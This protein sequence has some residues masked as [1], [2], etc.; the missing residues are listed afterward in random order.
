M[1]TDWEKYVIYG[2]I[3]ERR[4][5]INKI[6]EEHFFV[7]IATAVQLFVIANVAFKKRIQLNKHD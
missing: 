2:T 1:N 3:N 7:N 4:F 5:S 6:I